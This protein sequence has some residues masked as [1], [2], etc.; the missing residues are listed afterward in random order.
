MQAVKRPGNPEIFN[1]TKEKETILDGSQYEAVTV[2]AD[3]QWKRRSVSGFIMPFIAYKTRT[4]E[5]FLGWPNISRPVMKELGWIREVRP[6]IEQCAVNNVGHMKLVCDADEVIYFPAVSLSGYTRRSSKCIFSDRYP[7]G[8][9][10]PELLVQRNLCY[11]KSSCDITWKGEDRIVVSKVRKCIGYSVASIGLS[12]HRCVKK[13]YIHDVCTNL[14]QVIDSSWGIIRSHQLYPWYFDADFPECKRIIK[15]GKRHA[16]LLVVQDMNLDPDG[17]DKFSVLHCR[18][19]VKKEVM[20]PKTGTEGSQLI[21]RGGK[22]VIK[23]KPFKTSKAGRGFV[24]VFRRFHVS[25]QELG[26]FGPFYSNSYG[27]DMAALG[28]SASTTTSIRLSNRRLC[29]AEKKKV[30]KKGHACNSLVWTD[31]FIRLE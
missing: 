21:V 10:T 19:N 6:V 13:D 5:A 12:G 9:F 23:F 14:T 28:D 22:L 3:F 11:W 7:C 4:L 8:G 18:H 26:F 20:N 16:L 31:Y 1:V 25:K 24:L 15:I 29:S 2:V 27:A 17:R 30:R